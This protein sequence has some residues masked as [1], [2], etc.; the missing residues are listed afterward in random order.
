[1]DCIFVIGFG[2]SDETAHRDTSFSIDIEPRE[3]PP[4]DRMAESD[5]IDIAT[6]RKNA[7]IQNLQLFSPESYQ[8][9]LFPMSGWHR[10]PLASPF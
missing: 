5:K 4:Y 1:M 7:V 10:L 2:R 3:K 9:D 8:I 6:L